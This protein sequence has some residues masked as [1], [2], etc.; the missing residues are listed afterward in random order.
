MG[1]CFI[2]LYLLFSLISINFCEKKKSLKNFSIIT[3]K[4]VFNPGTGVA[5]FSGYAVNVD[6]ESELK[7]QTIA[8]QRNDSG[9]Y[10]PSS[11]ST[12]YNTQLNPNMNAPNNHNLLFETT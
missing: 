9:S 3:N 1:V 6:L 2:V 7:N 12:L 8:L 4:K 5:P 11:N 10:I